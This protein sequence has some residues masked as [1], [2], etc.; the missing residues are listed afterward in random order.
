MKYEF[1]TT[2]AESSKTESGF[3]EMYFT[4]RLL[5]CE[6][7]KKGISIKN[8]AG[9]SLRITVYKA[10]ARKSKRYK[11]ESILGRGKILTLNV[12]CLLQILLLT[13]YFLPITSYIAF[14]CSKYYILHLTYY[15]LIYSGLKK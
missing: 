6:K 11:Q 15:I 9:K 8:A 1:A 14:G 10:F 4:R 13:Y 12:V 7:D 5:I 2:L 3:R